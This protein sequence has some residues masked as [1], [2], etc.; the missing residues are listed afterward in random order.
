[1][2]NNKQVEEERREWLAEL[3]R[4][5]R[6]EQERIERQRLEE[7]RRERDMQEIRQREEKEREE[8]ERLER[9]EREKKGREVRQ[10]DED[11][12]MRNFER[13]INGAE[14]MELARIRADDSLRDRLNF[15][16]QNASWV[17]KNKN[18]E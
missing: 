9:E 13:M 8:K 2:Q 16:L 15:E 12:L 4:R 10:A 18:D 3:E 14:T 11:Q 17:L 6:I 7:L 5:D 1:M